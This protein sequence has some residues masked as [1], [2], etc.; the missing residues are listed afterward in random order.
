MSSTLTVT[1]YPAPAVELVSI[2]PPG[3]R[4]RSVGP[5]PARHEGTSEPPVRFFNTAPVVAVDSKSRSIITA[6]LVALNIVQFISNFV[7]IAGGLALSADLGR[8]ADGAGQANWMAAAYP[9]TQGAF[10]L[11]TGRLG[12]VHGHQK[13]V[14]LGS[15]AFS[16]F[17]L[18]NAFCRT[19]ESFV[20]MRALT[21]IGGGIFMPNAVAIITT[22][23]PPGRSRN[24][25]MGFFAAAPPIGGV[26]GGV[27]AGVFTEVADWKWLFVLLAGSSLAVTIPLAYLLPRELPVDRNGKIDY[28]GAFLGL[29]SLV[30]FNFV[31]NQA[32]AVGW[33]TP[34]VIACLLI[35]VSLFAAFLVWEN[36]YA[37]EPIMP[38]QVFR[39]PSFTALIFVVLLTYMSIGILMWYSVTWQ[40]V[41]RHASVMETGL[42][43]IPFGFGSVSSVALAAWLLPRVSA[44]WIVAIGIGT[45][46]LSNLLLA[47]MPVQQ[48]YWAQVFPAIL[49]SSFCPDLVYVAAQ[50]IASNSVGRR[51]Q[52]AAGS[53]IG[54]L[55]LYGNSLGLGFAGTIES[56]VATGTD[57]SEIVLGYRAALFFGVALGAAAL[58]LNFVFVRM[59]KDERQGWDES[60]EVTEPEPSTLLATAIDRQ[61]QA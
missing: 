49:I 48:T 11:I 60:L 38:L 32:P 23:V 42:H 58:I 5:A 26:I 1:A 17:A 57:I 54:T 45:A 16:L 46:L 3:R 37:K 22:M 19:Y 18:A 13:L 51:H 2:Q 28:M 8:D 47:T 44:Q 33:N 30:L 10:V 40:Q 36:K 55:N 52:G 25:T 31:W 43:F 12:S 56:R 6:L 24:L 29:G 61:T 34:Y 50:L 41:L 4:S 7:T 35:S 27:L 39:A 14:V 59:P 9:L 15:L 53:L 20:A 21:G